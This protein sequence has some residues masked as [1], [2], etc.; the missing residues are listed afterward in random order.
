MKLPYR[1]SCRCDEAQYWE[2][3]AM[4]YKEILKILNDGHDLDL[5][6]FYQGNLYCLYPVAQ[7][8]L[9][10]MQKEHSK[11]NSWLKALSIWLKKAE[12]K[13]KL[14]KS[15]IIELRAEIKQLKEENNG[16]V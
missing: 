9:K 12:D 15:K 16:D 1:D 7:A 3:E 14:L 8:K 5:E 6:G 2:S 4:K 10:K 11:Q 13:I